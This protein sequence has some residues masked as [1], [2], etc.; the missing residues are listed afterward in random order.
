MASHYIPVI[1][2]G[3]LLNYI[4][5]HNQSLVFGRLGSLDKFVV[6]V[7]GAHGVGQLAEVHLEQGGHGVDVLQHAA[8][9]VQIWHT[10][11]V[12]GHPAI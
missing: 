10:I 7:V 2:R 5:H 6:Q 1:R 8:V 9:V 3:Q 11:L 4:T 12:K